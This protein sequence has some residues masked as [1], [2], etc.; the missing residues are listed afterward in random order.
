MS[1]FNKF[2]F[3]YHQI[4]DIVNVNLYSPYL[5][6]H[7]DNNVSRHGISTHVCH[8]TLLRRIP[9]SDALSENPI[10]SL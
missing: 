7:V 9:S 3:D 4:F 2:I 5:V 6:L 8:C 1:I 10:R